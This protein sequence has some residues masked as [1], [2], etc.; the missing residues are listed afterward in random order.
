MA[1]VTFLC[2]HARFVRERTLDV[3]GRVLEGGH[4]FINVGARPR[5]PDFPGL[6]AVDVLTSASMM[7]V[8]FLPEHLLIV[9]GSYIGLEFAQMY[10][11]FGARVTVV[12]TE[13]ESSERPGGSSRCSSTRRAT[14]F[15]APRLRGNWVPLSEQHCP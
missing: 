6:E 8:N 2:G 7:E 10:R 14:R 13:R 1:N 4:I 3:A 11:R 5:V 15:W 12:E 9:G